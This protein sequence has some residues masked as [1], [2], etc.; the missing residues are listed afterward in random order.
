[1]AV[2]YPSLWIMSF[3]V[4]SLNVIYYLRW[5]IKGT[6]PLFIALRFVSNTEDA[7]ALTTNE[8][9]DRSQR[10]NLWGLFFKHYTW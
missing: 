8:W 9:D 5:P 4:Y 10:T 6:Y 7:L 3:E 1:M 2:L